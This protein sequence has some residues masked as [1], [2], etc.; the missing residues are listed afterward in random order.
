[1]EFELYR[2]NIHLILCGVLIFLYGCKTDV[3]SEYL[4]EVPSDVAVECVFCPSE[5]W[6]VNIIGIS[7]LNVSEHRNNRPK[8]TYV[9]ILEDNNRVIELKFDS[10]SGFYVNDEHPQ[11]GHEYKL[12]VKIPNK[13]LITAKDCI[14][15]KIDIIE[16]KTKKEKQPFSQPGFDVNSILNQNMS[17][18]NVYYQTIIRF[19]QKQKDIDFR[20]KS[21]DVYQIFDFIYL[22]P[23]VY[24]TLQNRGVSESLIN[25][26]R[27]VA[28]DDRLTVSDFE[29]LETNKLVPHDAEWIRSYLE[30]YFLPIINQ[31]VPKN[32]IDLWE[33]KY[34]NILVPF[35]LNNKDCFELSY[36]DHDLADYMFRG[37]KSNDFIFNQ[38]KKIYDD[39]VGNLKYYNGEKIKIYDDNQ[40][41]DN[42]FVDDFEEK[43]KTANFNAISI[44]KLQVVSMSES[45]TIY[46]NDAFYQINMDRD[47]HAELIRLKTNVKNAAGIFAGANKSLVT[48]YC[49]N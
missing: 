1:M 30:K 41:K 46:L 16:F 39:L 32:Q 9:R 22:K 36:K 25:N 34:H 49:H 18:N 37:L 28:Q 19:N 45:Y 4:S 27:S 20:L 42:G 21:Y 38:S 40:Y 31:I 7:R 3:T 33:K 2:K 10:N 35:L 48:L 14:P 11:E 17:E 29:S 15:P 44:R 47:H 26:L 24:K 13:P 5:S 43:L 8:V 12:E 6:K 23:N